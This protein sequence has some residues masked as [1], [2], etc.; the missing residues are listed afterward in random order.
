[1]LPA[2]GHCY[3]C[4]NASRY[5]TGADR[6]AALQA[7]KERIAAGKIRGKRP[8]PQPSL[9]ARQVAEKIIEKELAVDRSPVTERKQPKVG[10]GVPI[11]ES[12]RRSPSAISLVISFVGDDLKLY[13]GL[14]ARA[15]RE[16]RDPD[17]QLLFLLSHQLLLEVR[18]DG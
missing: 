16:R 14:L 11:G 9:G 7:V 17:Q 12:T 1:M 3:L 18:T 15:R 8:S 4:Y 13:E 6:E 5:L 2:V 10:R